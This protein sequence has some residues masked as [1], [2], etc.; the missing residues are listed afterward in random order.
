[1]F[2]VQDNLSEYS[3]EDLERDLLRLPRWRRELAL[4]FVFHEGRR[5]CTLAYLLLCRAL[6]EGYG[7]TAQP[8]FVVGKHGKPTLAEYPHIHFNLSHCSTAIICA[9]SD[10]PI[11]VDIENTRRK[12]GDSLIRHTMS[13]EEQQLIAE[14]GL[15]RFFSL[16][17]RKEALVKLWGTGLQDDIPELLSH[18]NTDGVAFTT[19]EHSEKGYVF[20]IAQKNLTV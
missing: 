12:V 16:W 9:V 8:T 2:L 10:H 17:T 14:H 7:I 15:V 4:K 18:R 1:M 3:A 6:R 19:E 11:G 5:N 13:E 20:S